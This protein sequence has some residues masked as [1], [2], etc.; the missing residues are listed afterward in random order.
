MD[1][2]TQDIAPTADET[3]RPAPA[4]VLPV[5]ASPAAQ[6]DKT[7]IV[8]DVLSEWMTVHI[9]NSP[10]AQ[11]TAAFN[12]LCAALPALRDALLRSL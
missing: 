3:I 2:V 10:V 5:T 6:A 7:G 1:T 12:H 4:T 8:N 9:H 11:A